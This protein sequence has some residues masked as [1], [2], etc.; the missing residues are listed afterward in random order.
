MTKKSFLYECSHN[1]LAVYEFELDADYEDPDI[2][3][4]MRRPEFVVET[5]VF[6]EQVE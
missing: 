6:K 4:E 1:P 3:H 2:P 5:A